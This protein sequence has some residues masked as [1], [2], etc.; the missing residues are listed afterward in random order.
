MEESELIEV[1]EELLAIVEDQHD[2]WI[3]KHPHE[4]IRQARQAIAK[5]KGGGYAS[6]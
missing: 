5:A 2:G 1:L 3:S 4:A 6:L